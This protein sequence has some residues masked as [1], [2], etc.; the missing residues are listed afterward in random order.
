MARI[1]YQ[2]VDKVKL[3]LPLVHLW[4]QGVAGA[5]KGSRSHFSSELNNISAPSSHFSHAH[6]RAHTQ[7]DTHIHT[8]PV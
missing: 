4:T 2:A 1:Q 6:A 7:I 8:L 3:L 5:P